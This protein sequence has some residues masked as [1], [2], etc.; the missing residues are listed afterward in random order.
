MS[1]VNLRIASRRAIDYF[2]IMSDD[3][4]KHYNVRIVEANL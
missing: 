2:V 4:A 3:A 1:G